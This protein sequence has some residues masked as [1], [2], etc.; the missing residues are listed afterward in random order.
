[1]IKGFPPFRLLFK[2]PDE[3]P[4]VPQIDVGDLVE[5]PGVDAVIVPEFFRCDR[6][7]FADV[8]DNLADIV[9]NASGR[10]RGVGSFFKGDDIQVRPEPF[11]LGRRT[12]ARRIPADDDESF[13]CHIS[14]TF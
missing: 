4:A 8:V 5:D 13:L 1:M 11:C 14:C 10:V 12:H 7:E 2:R 3:N 9:R 6:D